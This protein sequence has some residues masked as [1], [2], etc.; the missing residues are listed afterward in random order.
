MCSLFFLFHKYSPILT[1]F[2][3]FSHIQGVPFR[4]SHD[5]AGKS[6]A[7]CTSK[8]CQLLDLSLDELRSINPV[9]EKDV[10][11]FLGVENAIQKFI[12]YGSTG[13][14]CVA[15]QLDYWIKKLEI[16]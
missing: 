7:L 16:K 4:T 15:D 3:V 9:F 1:F 5:I 8:N 6:V 12:S 2:F 14:A 13:S 11:E 10:Y